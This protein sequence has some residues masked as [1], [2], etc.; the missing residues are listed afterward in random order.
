M[1]HRHRSGRVRPRSSRRLGPGVLAAAATALILGLATPS[2]AQ[3]YPPGF[4]DALVVSGLNVPTTF[5]FLPDGRILIAEQSG[6]IRIADNGVVLPTP[7][8]TIPVESFDEQGLLGLAIDPDFPTPAHL[9]VF[10]TP[11][12]GSQT[13]NVNRVSRFTMGATT[14][15]PQSEVIVLDDIP[16]GLGFHLGGCLRFGADENLYI[17]TGDTGWSTPYP[18]D[19]GL[20]QGKI[21]RIHKDGS[22]PA[23]NPF[24]SV[25]GARDE[26]YQWGLRNPFRFAVKP[27]TSKIFIGDVGFNSWEEIDFGP[28]GA[29]FGWPNCEGNCGNPAFTNPIYQYSHTQGSAAIVGNVFYQGSNFPAEFSGNYF[30]FDHSRGH[31]GR[32]ILGANDQVLSVSLPFIETASEGWGFGPVDLVLGPDGALYYCTYFPGQ[33]RRIFYTGPGNRNPTAVASGN[34]TAGYPSLLVNFDGD[35]SFDVDGNPLTYE[36]N[37]GDATAHS[38]LANPT[39]SYTTN[40]IYPATLTVRD[41]LGGIATSPPIAITVG[42]LPPTLSIVQPLPG[43]LFSPDDLVLFS[44]TGTDPEE[45]LLAGSELHWRVNLHHLNHIHPVILDQTGASGSFIADDHGENLADISYRIT[46]WAEDSTGLRNEVFID[47]LPDL[48]GPQ[49]ILQTFLVP[50]N[51]RDAT[52]VINDVRISGYSPSEPI[53]FAGNDAEQES[54]AMEFQINIPDGSDILEANLIVTAGPFQNASPTGAMAIRLYNIADALPFQ[55]GPFGDLVNHHP[56]HP[57]TVAWPQ[58][59]NWPAG[60]DVESPDIS[61]LMQLWLDLPAYSPGKHVG[62]VITKGTIQTGRYYGWA[63][64]AAPEDPPRLEVRYLPPATAAPETKVSKAIALFAPRPN[65]FRTGTE[66]GFSLQQAGTVRLTIHDAG[67]RL[68]RTMA[69]G[70]RESGVHSLRVGW[71]R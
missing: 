35:N 69:D 63:D 10:Y 36:W 68:V 67:G 34:P 29:N 66:L 33:I 39:H 54:G 42:N 56:T 51:N 25:P 62:F 15:D 3:V 49:P 9:Y 26:I 53:D 31:L 22:I 20:L 7:A 41:G 43:T 19:L 17:S 5:A 1:L 47:V 52:S 40:G 6:A 30:F 23:D 16:A 55:N 21:L 2:G 18:Q 14:I 12:S 37:F 28:A 65:P 60:T 27:G 50:A 11:F 44:G 59:T 45:G 32:M 24:V 13:D 48:S 58:G 38:T 71:S 64:F 57:T 70:W 4:N 61:T 8:I 46:L